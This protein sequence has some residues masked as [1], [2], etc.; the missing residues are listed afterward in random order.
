MQE[1]QSISR[2]ANTISL[3]FGT[4]PITTWLQRFSPDNS[5]GHLRPATQRW[6]SRRMAGMMSD[7]LIVRATSPSS[8][9]DEIDYPGVAIIRPPSLPSKSWSETLHWTWQWVVLQWQDWTDEWGAHGCDMKRVH[10]WIDLH[11]SLFAKHTAH[12]SA[13]SVWYVDMVCVSPRYQKQGVGKKLMQWVLEQSKGE[14]CFL[15]CSA[16]HNVKFYEKLGFKVVEEVVVEDGGD[17][18]RVWCML[19]E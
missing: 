2:L 12:L 10:Q 11:E 4:D 6:Q 19:K 8:I 9:S 13:N 14:A 3:A 15:E 17:M 1:P 18:V 16:Q 5:W 7:H